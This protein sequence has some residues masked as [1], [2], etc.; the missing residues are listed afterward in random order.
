M[1]A[2]D[3]KISARGSDMMLVDASAAAPVPTVLPSG[4]QSGHGNDILLGQ[5]SNRKWHLIRKAQQSNR[6]SRFLYLRL[7]SY[8]N[9][10]QDN[11]E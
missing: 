10:N 1:D 6:E 7:D 2:V 8:G 5:I 4:K 11:N 3:V 9:N